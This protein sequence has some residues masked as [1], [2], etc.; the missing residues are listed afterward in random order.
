MQDGYDI[1]GL[2]LAVVPP[3][4]VISMVL[5]LGTLVVSRQPPSR[6]K[7][8]GEALA[9]TRAHAQRLRNGEYITEKEGEA[10]YAVL[11]RC[12][13]SAMRQWLELMLTA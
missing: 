4:L 1:S 8:I 5:W 7:E 11:N 3:S 6:W 13:L 2:V 10:V 12:E 9:E